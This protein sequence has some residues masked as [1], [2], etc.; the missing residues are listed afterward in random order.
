MADAGAGRRPRARGRA[1]VSRAGGGDG[2]GGG[3]R[4]ANHLFGSGKSC[5]AFARASVSLRSPLPSP[6]RPSEIS[7]WRQR[8]PGSRGAGRANADW[9]GRRN[10]TALLRSSDRRSERFRTPSPRGSR[11]ESSVRLRGPDARA[12]S[13]R[14]RARLVLGS[15]TARAGRDS[16]K[17]EAT[18]NTSN[19][20]VWQ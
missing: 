10:G 17:E 8:R 9:I 19:W 1:A 13:P 20:K 14:R 7:R 5:V 3:D 15:G 16:S 6:R 11:R 12:R 18:T 2:G 4:P